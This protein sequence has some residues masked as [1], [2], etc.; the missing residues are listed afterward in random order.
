MPSAGTP[1]MGHAI[2]VLASRRNDH[3][4]LTFELGKLPAQIE[5]MENRICKYEERG[6]EDW[7]AEMPVAAEIS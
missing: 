3:T 4:G 1:D 6:I 5:D 7:E 2:T